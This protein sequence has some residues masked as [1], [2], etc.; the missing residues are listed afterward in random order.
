MFHFPTE[1][2]MYI[3]SM[4]KSIMYR[5]NYLV[6]NPSDYWKMSILSSWII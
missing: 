5:V 3:C 6:D 1:I 4:I 2:C